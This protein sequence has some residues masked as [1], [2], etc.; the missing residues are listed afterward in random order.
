MVATRAEV[1]LRAGVSPAVVS[2]VTNPGTRS[3]SAAARARVEE[4]IATLGYRPNAVAQSLRRSSTKS[5]AF[6]VPTL[7]NPT[8]AAVEA[9]VE[10][11][12]F[13]LGYA[14]FVATTTNDPGREERYLQRFMERKVDALIVAGTLRP[15][16]LAEVAAHRVPV[17]ALGAISSGLGVS[18]ITLEPYQS[19]A[20]AIRHLIEDHGHRRIAC[21]GGPETQSL[22]RLRMDAW[23]ETLRAEGLACDESLLIRPLHMNRSAGY[24]AAHLLLAQSM[25][26][27]IFTV[28]ETLA[29]GAISAIHEHGLRVPKD[30]SLITWGRSE[31][32]QGDLF[33]L[34]SID[35]QTTA[36]A[37]K[38]MSRLL[39][40]MASKKLVETHDVLFPTLTFRTSCGCPPANKNVAEL[41]R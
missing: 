29:A 15:N 18:S 34:T 13:D 25:P 1:A 8:L 19:T 11:I 20:R 33:D 6:I 27:A 7:R 35:I 30:V 28:D 38:L 37:A 22:V 32:V 2:Y 12:A 21:I 3:V 14:L 9:D 5:I 31:R 40:L 17:V 36:V 4:A 16:L 23:R 41:S 24:N 39:E 10:K 26:T